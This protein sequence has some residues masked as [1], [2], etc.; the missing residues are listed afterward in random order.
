MIRWR[1]KLTIVFLLLVILFPS[2][3]LIGEELA[4]QKSL[5]T[6]EMDESF[7][8]LGFE[9]LV[10]GSDYDD[11]LSK[12]DS[13]NIFLYNS[14][15]PTW[16]NENPVIAV[17][18]RGFV[19]KGYFQFVDKKLYTITVEI[20]RNRMDYYTIFTELKKKYGKYKQFSPKMVVWES[21]AA[22][23]YLERPLTLK[24]LD[25]NLHSIL[26]D[27]AKIKKSKSQIQRENF[28]EQF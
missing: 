19:Q 26:L 28:L 12:L 14:E 9:N 20:N 5:E 15:Q 10:L 4:S 23:L 13:S 24:Y 17:E 21:D 11:V 16:I 2:F 18:G 8:I 1:Y 6:K 22:V 27:S 25:K 3:H 7:A